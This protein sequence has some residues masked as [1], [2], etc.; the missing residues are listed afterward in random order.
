MMVWII[1]AVDLQSKVWS[2]VFLG[3]W[4]MFEFR[5]P[6]YRHERLQ[7]EFY[8]F[9]FLS[10][11]TSLVMLFLLLLQKVVFQESVTVRKSD[12][13]QKGNV[14]VLS[15]SAHSDR[16]VSCPTL[17]TQTGECPVLLCTLR[18]VSVLSYSAYSDR[19]VSC[20]TLH[21]QTDKL[22]R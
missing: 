9:S 7:I 12:F 22:R 17:H 2:L 14:S 13:T 6:L 21:T 1:S 15:Y 18:Q 11:I 5:M 20:P 3:K 19:R 10:R 4:N 16:W 8:H